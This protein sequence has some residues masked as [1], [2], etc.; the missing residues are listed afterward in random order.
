MEAEEREQLYNATRSTVIALY[1]R[2]RRHIN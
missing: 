2:L 1:K